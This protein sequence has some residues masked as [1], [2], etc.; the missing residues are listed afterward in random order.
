MSLLAPILGKLSLQSWAS[1]TRAFQ[2]VIELDARMFILGPLEL[3]GLPAPLLFLTRRLEQLK[4]L[5]LR[6]DFPTTMLRL[7]NNLNL[8]KLA[9]L[10]Q[11]H[12][13]TLKVQ[14]CL[15][16]EKN[17]IGCGLKCFGKMIPP[18]TRF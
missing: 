12:G 1:A 8:C 18:P 5:Q 4:L 2:C 17:A 7:R 14:A 11:P 6:T 13:F 10:V 9:C 15:Q 16:R 3:D